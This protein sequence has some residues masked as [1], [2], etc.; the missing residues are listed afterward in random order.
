[1]SLNKPHNPPRQA[2]PPI[3]PTRLNAIQRFCLSLSALAIGFGGFFGPAMGQAAICGQQGDIK[4]I[5]SERYK[6]SQ[7]AFGLV[8]DR[9]LVE[10][11]TSENG[12]WSILMTS[13][14]GRTCVIA[15]GH[16]WQELDQ[17]LSG[18]AA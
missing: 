10:V 15:A 3:G 18:P 5:L 17:A 16:T 11:F 1:M 13:P 14:T 8:S 4:K 6:E 12:T 2:G 9:G 7:R